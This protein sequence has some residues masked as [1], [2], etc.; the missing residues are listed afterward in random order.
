MHSKAEIYFTQQR[1]LFE[2]E[3]KSLK[4]KLTNIALLR[5]AVF[6]TGLM[7]T[8]YLV[9]QYNSYYLLT[10]LPF[11]AAFLVLL[12]KNEVLLFRKNYALNVI[13]ICDQEL[14][15]LSGNYQSFDGGNEFKNAEH[16][17]SSDLDIFGEHSIFCM[18]N[19][20][21][22]FIG[23]IFL[24]DMLQSKGSK[25]EILKRQQTIQ[26]LH[27]NSELQMDFRAK[28]MMLKNNK[29]EV[30][31]ILN[32]T[33]Q[34]DVFTKKKTFRLV[35]IIFP[36]ITLTLLAGSFFFF[37]VEF[38][39]VSFI[40]QLLFTGMFL[41]KIN[42]LHNIVS[43]KHN[44]LIHF[45]SLF[46]IIESN[47]FIS[48]GLTELKSSCFNN[49][50]SATLQINRF[51]NLIRLFDNRLNMLAALLLNGLFL[52]DLQL[53]IKSEKWKE[54]NKEVIEKWFK[55][56]AEFDAFISLSN[57]VFGNPDYVL[58]EIE[59][60]ELIFKFKDI[61]HPLIPLKERVSNSFLL[62]GEGNIAIVTGSNMAGKSTFLRTIGVN[63]VLAS[64][65]LTVCASEMLFNPV[66]LY[67]SMRIGDDLS[68][69]E[70][71]FYAE[72]KRLKH[73]LE[74]VDKHVVF[75]LLDEILKGTN[76]ADKLTGSK[77][78]LRQ[79]ASSSS[80]AVIATHDLA[81]GEMNAEFPEKINNYNFEVE[82]VNNEFYFDYKLK[83]GICKIMN[84]TE[85]M[86]KMGV[87]V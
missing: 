53:C 42:F 45:S 80:L 21:V 25:S 51:S 6:A 32:W 19:R 81:L 79:L 83:N 39:L 27:S 52:W 11:I 29:D 22:S 75:I 61:S 37:P 82:I 2:K 7:F 54:Q 28:G 18:L 41:R 85:L 38:F 56:L 57:Y 35:L 48:P 84:A 76:S 86:K 73:I 31:E 59:D 33:K 49:Q 3:L 5:L 60:K 74:A 67:S 72:L 46:E 70:S 63:M 47:N 64:A 69:R 13:K 55:A 23:K 40:S 4:R 68:N 8:V 44:M 24:A 14:E 16:P 66:Q 12:K 30:E 65:G 1:E 50:R 36:A 17:Y 77:A 10:S 62:Q 15:A 34:T 26:E 71:T 87:K 9:W 58:P 43:R 78:L 20:T